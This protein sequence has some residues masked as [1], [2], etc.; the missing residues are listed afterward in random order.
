MLYYSSSGG[1]CVWP[2]WLAITIVSLYQGAMCNKGR[3]MNYI[4]YTYIVH[5]EYI[6]H[7]ESKTHAACDT[8]NGEFAILMLRSCC[9]SVI[10]AQ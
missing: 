2:V 4:N 7:I 9:K 1:Q 5:A 10:N 8:V 3:V 6:Q